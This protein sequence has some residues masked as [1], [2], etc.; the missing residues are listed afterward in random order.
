MSLGDQRSEVEGQKSCCYRGRNRYRDQ[1][2][3]A[4]NLQANALCR[5]FRPKETFDFDTDNDPELSLATTRKRF[6][7]LN[8]ALEP[9][10]FFGLG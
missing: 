5:E 8:W 10:A 6:V 1:A 3:G 2:E 4:S 9:A 7:R